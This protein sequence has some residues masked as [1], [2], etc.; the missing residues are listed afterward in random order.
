MFSQ[1]E[2]C[3]DILAIFNLVVKIGT[4]SITSGESK[5]SGVCF[6]SKLSEIDAFLGHSS[7][8]CCFFAIQELP[9]INIKVLDHHRQVVL[10]GAS[11]VG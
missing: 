6:A 8:H 2:L 5:V 11:Q 4:C 1:R 9:T 10:T 3:I 7:F